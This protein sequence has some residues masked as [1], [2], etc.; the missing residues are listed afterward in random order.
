MVMKL[1]PELFKLCEAKLH[2]TR[3]SYVEMIADRFGDSE[4]TK[5][6]TSGAELQ[7][8]K[9]MWDAAAVRG[10]RSKKQKEAVQN[11]NRVFDEALAN[12]ELSG[13]HAAFELFGQSWKQVQASVMKTGSWSEE[14]EDGAI[15]I[16][17]KGPKHAAQLAK[18]EF[19]KAFDQDEDDD[20]DWY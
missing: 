5:Y 12:S 20:E 19:M 13:I 11:A 3:L 9:T 14:F 7:Q 8:L 16:S 15:A 4:T 18:V 17:A 10:A 2:G 6:V 1:L